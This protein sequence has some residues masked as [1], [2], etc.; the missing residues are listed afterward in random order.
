M[1]AKIPKKNFRTPEC[2]H[3]GSCTKGKLG[4]KVTRLKEE[5]S[6]EKLE[7]LY[8]SDYG[9]EIYKKRKSKVE[10]PF[11][12]IKRN[13]NGGYFLV[14]GLAGANIEMSIN[15]TCFNLVRMLTLLGGVRPFIEKMKEYMTEISAL[16]F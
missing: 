1:Q 11:G 16:N 14:R 3:Y 5:A 6:K 15:C 2:K 7:K 10:L 13:L 8:A 9:Q 4:R 12:H